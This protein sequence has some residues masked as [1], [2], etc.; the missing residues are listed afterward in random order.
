MMRAGLALLAIL[1]L[2]AGL[3]GAGGWL[4]LIAGQGGAT[5]LPAAIIGTSLFCALVAILILLIRKPR[6]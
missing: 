6:P 4:R 2:A 3:F 5:G 1:A